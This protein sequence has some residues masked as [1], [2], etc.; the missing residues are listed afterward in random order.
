M[1][2][3]IKSNRNSLSEKLDL[4]LVDS[5]GL[6]ETVSVSIS[7]CNRSTIKSVLSFNFLREINH[8]KNYRNLEVPESD[9]RMFPQRKAEVTYIITMKRIGPMS[10]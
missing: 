10:L 3:I 1:L 2:L 8:K 6:R 4:E 7:F 5:H 9:K